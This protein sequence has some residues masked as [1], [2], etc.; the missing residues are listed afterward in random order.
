MAA[1][2]R[3]YWSHKQCTKTNQYAFKY[4][5]IS[6]AYVVPAGEYDEPATINAMQLNKYNAGVVCISKTSKQMV[7]TSK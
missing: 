3:D 6:W 7:E 5:I 2:D 1:R 4:C